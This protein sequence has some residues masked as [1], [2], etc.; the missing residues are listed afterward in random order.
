MIFW[1]LCD[2]S[3]QVYC[4]ILEGRERA[5]HSISSP[6][7]SRGSQGQS[8]RHEF[9]CR[10]FMRENGNERLRE[11]RGRSRARRRSLLE[12][13]LSLIPGELW[14]VNYITDPV[15]PWGKKIGLLCPPSLNHWQ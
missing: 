6:P 9:G 14:C 13:S 10:G 4:K 7:L 11:D 3:L 5:L 1:Y 8:L 12:S 2:L 15:S